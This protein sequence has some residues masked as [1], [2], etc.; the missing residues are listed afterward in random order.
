[1]ELWVHRRPEDILFAREAAVLTRDCY[2]LTFLRRKK[3]L[4]EPNLTT[5]EWRR[6]HNEKLYALYSLP[7]IM[8][9]NKKT[10]KGRACSTYGGDV[11][12]GFL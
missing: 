5:W 10:E 7:N 9:V 8:Q 12:A 11:L 4:E 3:F 6:L 1:M 2:V